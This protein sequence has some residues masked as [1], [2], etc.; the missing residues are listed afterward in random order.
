MQHHHHSHAPARGEVGIERLVFSFVPDENARASALQA[1]DI[2]VD[3]VSLPPRTAEQVAETDGLK[4][5]R[6][7]GESTVLLLPEQNPLFADA[8]VREAVA[9]AVDRQAI[10]QG[11]FGDAASP[12]ATPI[13]PDSWAAS[14]IAAPARDVERARA[15]LDQAGWAA[16]SGGARQRG[17]TPLAFPITYSAGSAVANNTALALRDQLG[18][19]GMRVD[20]EGLGFDAQSDRLGEG[21]AT[22]NTQG[23]A[24][25][26]GL[27]MFRAYH[28]SFI[29]DGESFTA[30]TKMSNPA[31]DGALERARSSLDRGERAAAYAELE[32]A[33]VADASYLYLVRGQNSLVVSDRIQGVRPQV[34]EGHIHGFSRGLL[35]NVH[36]WTLAGT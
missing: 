28:S 35:W 9:L 30:A 27:T 20:L 19:V 16:G 36:E 22:L 12:T 13:P 6:I 33:L 7:P 5:V 8:A 3:A 21:T 11:V 25:D 4:L 2:D 10:V 24:Y 34:R 26:P 23:D 15:L 32:R 14:G 17:G 18:E 29:D 1:G 31:V